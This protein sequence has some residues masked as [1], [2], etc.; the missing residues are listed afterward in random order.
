MFSLRARL[1]AAC[2]AFYAFAFAAPSNTVAHLERELLGIEWLR[3]E[4][5]LRIALRF[6]GKRFLEVAGDEDDF[7]VRARDAE[8]VGEID[9]AHLRHHHVREQEVDLLIRV[10]H[11]E[12]LRIF[13]VGRFQH[14]VA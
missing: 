3:Q 10:K 7:R 4:K 13:A 11:D 9:S 14:F 6:A 5:H 8:P 1:A 12:P 2:L